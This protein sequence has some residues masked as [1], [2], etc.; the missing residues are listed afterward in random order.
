MSKIKN[1]HHL[2]MEIELE[3]E[4]KIH[5]TLKEIEAEHISK[6]REAELLIN[7]LTN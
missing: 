1:E 7:K 3:W 2:E 6:I 4:L 5:R